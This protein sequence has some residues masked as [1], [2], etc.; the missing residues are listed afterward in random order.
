M[1]I[2]IN[3]PLK[4]LDCTFRDGGYYTNWSFPDELVRDYISTMAE[5]PVD[6]I[7]LGYA[8]KTS[9]CGKFANVDNLLG[10]SLRPRADVMLAVMLDAKDYRDSG[11]IIGAKLD[12]D[13]GKRLQGGLDA[14][15]IAVNFQTA[16]RCGLLISELEKRGYHVFL[17]LMQID[18]ATENE[19]R[20]CLNFV[21]EMSCLEAVYIADSLGSMRPSRVTELVQTFADPAPSRIGFHAHENS[22]LAIA[23]S[24]CALNNGCTWL[25]STI[26]GM[27]RG[28]GNASTEQLLNAVEVPGFTNE[29]ACHLQHLITGHFE[30]LKSSKGWGY[31]MLYQTG[32]VQGLH[33]TYVQEIQSDTSLTAVQALSWLNAIP[34][35]SSKFDR[36]QLETAR[37]SAFADQTR[38]N[39]KLVGVA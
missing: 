25:D 1:Q 11:N 35:N 26:A 31:S 19:I 3:G 33:P 24:L 39:T 7:E 27:G 29:A 15:R 17:N 5:L 37:A 14:V 4:I 30:P 10:R 6:A 32:A 38:L 20:D 34:A 23:N 9:C 28:A 12:S 21:T 16:P 36:K 8:G 13:L 22:G 2:S 18:L